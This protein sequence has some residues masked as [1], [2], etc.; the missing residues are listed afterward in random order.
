MHGFEVA[1][2]RLEM[3][4][5]GGE[6]QLAGAAETAVDSLLRDQCLNRVDRVVERLVKRDR[7]LLAELRFGRQ[8]AMRK[9][10]VEVSAIA[11]GGAPA[12]LLRLQHDDLRARLGELPSSSEA[13]EAAAD[14]GDVEMAFDRTLSSPGKGRGGVVPVG[15]EFHGATPLSKDRRRQE[16]PKCRRS[17]RS[18]N[19]GWPAHGRDSPRPCS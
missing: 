10:V 9:S 1:C 5:L 18:R 4:R 15:Q 7:P 2:D 12:D 11:A 14:H 17:P 3:L 16:A 13:G 19:R 6:L 8:I